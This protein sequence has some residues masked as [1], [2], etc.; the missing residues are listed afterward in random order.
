MTPRVIVAAF[1]I[2]AGS[3]FAVAQTPGTSSTPPAVSDTKATPAKPSSDEKRE[4]AA[5]RRA[6]KKA[7]RAEKK[8][9]RI[10][11]RKTRV[12]CYDDGRKRSLKGSDLTTFVSSC[13]RK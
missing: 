13:I 6:E 5:Q 4:A 9:Q 8:A 10:A 1:C 11:T 12:E 7:A 3:S 2:T